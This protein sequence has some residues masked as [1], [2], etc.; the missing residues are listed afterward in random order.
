MGQAMPAGAKVGGATM[1]GLTA[2]VAQ[3]FLNNQLNETVTSRP[4]G[5]L[6]WMVLD[7]MELKMVAGNYGTLQVPEITGTMPAQPMLA[8]GGSEITVQKNGYLFVFVSNA[9]EGAVYFDDLSV[10]HTPGPL[11]EE[12]HYYPSGLEMFALGSSASNGH[13]RNRYAYQGQERENTFAL[14][15][16]EFEARHYDPQLG[17]WM[18]PDP[19]NQ[20]P[21]PY[22]G[23]GNEWVNGVDP[24]GRVFIAG[25]VIAAIVGGIA[26][27]AKNWEEISSSRDFGT[28]FIRALGYAASGAAGAYA[29]YVWGGGS[30]AGGLHGALLG[31]GLTAKWS[32]MTYRTTDD[33]MQ[34]IARGFSASLM[35]KNFGKAVDKGFKLN[36]RHF[37]P[38]ELTKKD[39]IDAEMQRNPLKFLYKIN[40]KAI[41]LNEKIVEKGVSNVAAKY[42]TYGKYGT[43][44]Y[45]SNF[46]STALWTGAISGAVNFGLTE[47]IASLNGL[48]NLGYSGNALFTGLG[49]G[50]GSYYADWFKNQAMYH[51]LNNKYRKAFDENKIQ[52]R[53]WSAIQ[54][55][56]LFAMVDFGYDY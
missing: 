22:V 45:G 33:D 43:S 51:N 6:N 7:E 34:Y 35:G 30:F 1:S 4:R 39:A 40:S 32:E 24:D 15:L 52:T 2:G 19:A 3:L 14:N 46:Y 38:E 21:S 17:R 47:G 27:V 25:K 20:F 29:G 28:G 44:N 56:G 8:A 53:F 55:L 18:V 9:S 11:L 48:T 16:N 36:P 49:Y 12:H 10:T 41:S 42:G 50:L 13:V 54:G 5:F 26:N 31:G 23:M 37:S